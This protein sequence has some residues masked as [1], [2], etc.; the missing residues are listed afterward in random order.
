MVLSKIRISLSQKQ[1]AQLG[2]VAG[3]ILIFA[4][5][6]LIRY[7]NVV[8]KADETNRPT[9]ILPV[10]N[11]RY[12]YLNNPLI[13][14]KATANAEVTVKDN[15][16]PI[17]TATA[18]TNGRFF[19]KPEAGFSDGVHRIA[20]TDSV[21]SQSSTTTYV[22]FNT[23]DPKK[24]IL[25]A[26]GIQI[27]ENN[28]PYFGNG[29]NNF[30]TII[31][32]STDKPGIEKQFD[33]LEKAG[34]KMV[35]I[36][37]YMLRDM[38]LPDPVSAPTTLVEDGGGLDSGN[39]VYRYTCANLSKNTHANNYDTAE[40]LP[41]PATPVVAVSQGQKVTLTLP[42]CAKSYR[43]F[44]YRRNASEVENS[45]GLLG[46][47]EAPAGTP[48]TFIDDG[49]YRPANS[50]WDAPT[51][52]PIL[53]KGTGSQL[54]AGTYVYRYAVLAP[55]RPGNG[56]NEKFVYGG[57]TMASPTAEITTNGNEKVIVTIP[58]NNLGP[59]VR[60]FRRL[61]SDPVDSERRMSGGTL[62]TTIGQ[63]TWTDDN[64]SFS[65][66]EK[67]PSSNTTAA[68]TVPAKNETMDNPS[69]YGGKPFMTGFGNWNEEK[70]IDTDYALDMAKRHNIRL[71]F[72]FVDQHDNLTGGVREIARN[73]ATWNSNF[74]VDTCSKNL[75]KEIIDKFT[76]RTNT[77][78]GTPYKDDPAIFAWEFIN[79]PW[80][81]GS[82]G[83]F[84]NWLWEMGT[85]LK[86]KDPNHML[87]SG[88]DGSVWFT[89][90]YESAYNANNNHDFVTSG[91]P[92]PIDLLTW[93]GYPEANGFMF[94]HGYYG[95]F[96]P[97]DPAKRGGLDDA[98]AAVWLEKWGPVSGPIDIAG[99]IK[100]L[101]RHAYYAYLLNK[102]VVFGEW[103]ISNWKTPAANDWINQISKAIL[104][105]KPDLV[106]GA[107]AIP[108]GDFSE[109]LADNWNYDPPNYA[110][111]TKDETTT[112]NNHPTA[113]ITPTYILDSAQRQQYRTGV[114]SKK[115]SI[116]PNTTYWYEF[117]YNNPTDNPLSFRGS[118]Y[119]NGQSLNQSFET[120][121][122]ASTGWNTITRLNN[123]RCEIT[124]P[125]TDE[126]TLSIEL[127][128]GREADGDHAWIGDVNFYEL[129]APTTQKVGST[130]ASTGWWGVD[131]NYSIDSL[132]TAAHNFEIASVA[133]LPPLGSRS[134]DDGD[135]GSND[136]PPPPPPEK[137]KEIP[138]ETPP[139]DTITGETEPFID[140]E[141]PLE[142]QQEEAAASQP[143]A[144]TSQ[145]NEPQKIS[146]APAGEQGHA[147]L[148][149]TTGKKEKEEPKKS[150]FSAGVIGLGAFGVLVILGLVGLYFYQ[151]KKNR[152]EM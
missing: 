15:N 7:K 81:T 67:V 72:T 34:I 65:G 1:K 20:V 70:L 87:S 56:I 104:T 118:Y 125:D 89:H 127:I 92:D 134:P 32:L 24:A 59:W 93:H 84:R 54:A 108:D 58:T 63:T 17:G 18:D 48:A 83:R 42:A 46:F 95:E 49:T 121:F 41:S 132:L 100:E 45:E 138:I 27:I 29:T 116:K 86:S 90:N 55:R 73:C 112:Y 79:E 110:Y 135:D 10:N 52:P 35:R 80:E 152:D 57:I 8:F 131:P 23:S 150:K 53:T 107:D 40:T 103:G 37:N 43:Y 98:A 26:Q 149:T 129:V 148:A 11:G 77:I 60:I 51:A 139:E 82:G 47:A 19:F 62:R 105:V 146:Q 111:F 33:D 44:I 38:K 31:S 140:E 136:K 142:A 39:Y 22:E 85:Y 74:F 5:G 71:L 3:V 120:S 78:T 64:A 16:T 28:H 117:T 145:E 137:P 109:N 130:F 21:S 126:L 151:K 113:K 75:M 119:K 133:D 66:T 106:R 143:S 88:D 4:V 101:Q 147:N 2:V 124:T 61:S 76:T 9:I 12:N 141:T 114:V 36:I 6:V 14:G 97:N 115:F 99:T 50:A 94:N 128:N 123:Y 102:P 91:L 30:W 122:G 69:T 25:K 13:E 144:S 68:I 96:N